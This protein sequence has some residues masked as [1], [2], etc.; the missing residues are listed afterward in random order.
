[1]KSRPIIMTG[2]MAV[3][4]YT[5]EKGETRRPI[6]PQTWTWENG[7]PR[8][9][10]PLLFREVR[11]PCGVPGDELWVREAFCYQQQ[12]GYV[13]EEKALYKADGGEVYKDDGDGGIELNKDGTEASPWL[14]SIYM[15]RWA[16][17][18]TL[19]V[20]AIRAERLQE[21]TKEGVLAEG[22]SERDG[23][24]LKDCHAGWHEPFAQLWDSIY[25]K[26]PELQWA[27]DPWVWVVGFRR[28]GK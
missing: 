24:P 25:A 2:D 19:I 26:K 10:N 9:S 21:I 14:P 20:R 12:D 6:K 23:C 28:K 1:M 16:S 27:A 15:P 5:G 7:K 3:K 22:I 17:R 11:C 4:S 8:L 13:I 18:T